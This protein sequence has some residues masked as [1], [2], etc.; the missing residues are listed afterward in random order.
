MTNYK[1]ISAEV[2]LRPAVNES[3]HSTRKLLRQLDP[4]N[5]DAAINPTIHL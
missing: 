5:S 1:M 4:C 2:F 3:A